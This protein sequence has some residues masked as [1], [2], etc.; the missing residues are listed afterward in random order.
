L[1][2]NRADSI[3]NITPRA[4]SSGRFVKQKQWESWRTKRKYGVWVQAP[5]VREYHPQKNFGI[6]DASTCNLAALLAGKMV[7]NA[8]HNAFLN[9]LTM[10]GVP[11]HSPPRNGPWHQGVQLRSSAETTG[12]SHPV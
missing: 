5:A 12:A 7:R 11:T 10:G 8:V 6:V 2:F 9:D 3:S 1:Y 4:P